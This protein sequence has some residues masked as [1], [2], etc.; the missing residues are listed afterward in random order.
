VSLTLLGA[1]GW[2]P[3]G[4]QRLHEKPVTDGLGSCLLPSPQFPSFSEAGGLSSNATVYLS[5]TPYQ[6][7]SLQGSIAYG[8]SF[9]PRGVWKE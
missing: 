3:R 8:L 1:L 9:Q 4:C 5:L 2:E 6:T 7:S